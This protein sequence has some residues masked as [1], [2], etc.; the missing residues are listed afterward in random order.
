[1][2]TAVVVCCLGLALTALAAPPSDAD[3]LFR[4]GVGLFNKKKFAEA[5]RSFEAAFEA[6]PNPAYLFNAATAYDKAGKLPEALRLYQKFAV[7]T[8]NPVRIRQAKDAIRDLEAVLA[9]TLGH[10]TV[11][12]EP[13]GAFLFL[14][15]DP[16]PI[17]TP[18]E[19]WLPPGSHTLNLKMLGHVERKETLDLAV[20]ELKTL[21]L[22]L[23]PIVLTGRAEVG[24]TPEGATVFIDGEKRGVT[25]LSLADVPVGTHR[26]RLEQ[27][28][29][30]ALEQ[31]LVVEK[32]G[33]VRVA[34]RLVPAPVELPRD[35]PVPVAP[36]PSIVTRWWF[37]T[38]IAVAVSGAVV[39]TVLA[40]R[41]D[42]AEGPP[43]ADHVWTLTEPGK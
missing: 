5:A 11:E 35:V 16:A 31:D 37:W 3:R 42:S 23:A 14:D 26:L 9:K 20:G 27:V 41:G 36:S 13:Q 39:A 30:V 18:F 7:T 38:G 33:D 10:L 19:R 4:E 29:F 12:V 6:T 34:L 1:M 15:G 32:D 40:T 43:P 28:G 22:R 2:R 8:D 25:P 21:R 24:S 17:Q